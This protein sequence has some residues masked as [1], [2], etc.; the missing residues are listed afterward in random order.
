MRLGITGLLQN[1]MQVLAGLLDHWHG[2]LEVSKIEKSYI[3]KFGHMRERERRRT[4]G[5]R[6]VFSLPAYSYTT[7]LFGL[8]TGAPSPFRL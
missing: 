3:G 4:A 2:E 1:Y 6:S 7:L 8:L 5:H